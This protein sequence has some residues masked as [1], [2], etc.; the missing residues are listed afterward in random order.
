MDKYSLNEFTIIIDDV[1]K[2]IKVKRKWE[3]YINELILEYATSCGFLFGKCQKRC[4]Y[5]RKSKVG[6]YI[7]NFISCDDINGRIITPSIQFDVVKLKFQIHLE[8][9]S[10][11]VIFNFVVIDNKNSRF[12]YMI[13]FHTRTLRTVKN[14]DIVCFSIDMNHNIINTTINNT[15]AWKPKIFMSNVRK[16]QGFVQ[17]GRGSKVKIV[18]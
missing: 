4:I 18:N 2:K 5:C 9:R 7:N 8:D 17:F 10:S 1:I 15:I 12:T 11:F 13:K 6:C 14:M 3:I 16:L